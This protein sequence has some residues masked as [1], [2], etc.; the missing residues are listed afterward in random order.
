MD[1]ERVYPGETV[2]AE[3]TMISDLFF[4][5][6]LTAGMEF[7]FREGATIIGEG[8]IPEIIN[9]RLQKAST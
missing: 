8:T 2:T 5:H 3:I 4:E 7:E 1:K 9:S 6:Q